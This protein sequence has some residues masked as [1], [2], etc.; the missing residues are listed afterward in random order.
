MMEQSDA[1]LVKACRGGNELAW[2]ALV[3]RYQRL[4]YT[5]PRRAGLDE[6]TASEIFQNV[7]AIFIENLDTI[8]QPERIGAWLTTTAKRETWRLIFKA[9]KLQTETRHQ[10]VEET[11]AFDFPDH[12]PLPDEVLLALESQNQVRNAVE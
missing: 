10:S 6:D 12:S 5:I 1:E 2:E 9:K 3:A 8:E 4:I 11:E 7:F